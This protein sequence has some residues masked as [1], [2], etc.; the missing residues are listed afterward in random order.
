MTRP[1]HLAAV[2]VAVLL[3][4]AAVGTA[5]A[6]G[7]ADPFE[8]PNGNAAQLL[9]FIQNTASKKYDQEGVA[10]ARQAIIK[11][12]SKIIAGKCTDNELFN[13]VNW[14]A[15]LL[16]PKDAEALEN[17]LK[18]A[19]KGPAA[20]MAHGATLLKQLHEAKDDLKALRG[21][22]EEARK[23]LDTPPLPL[24]CLG[25]A[26]AVGEAVDRIDNNKFACQTYESLQ[27]SL[28]FAPLVKD[29]QEYRK[30]TFVLN[31]LKLVG[32]KM[33]L[34]AK[35]L[36]GDSVKL[37]NLRGKV[38]LVNFWSSA[39]TVAWKRSTT[40]RSNTRS[41]TTRGSRSVGINVDATG[42]VQL[43]ELVKKED[44]PVDDL[45]RRRRSPLHGQPVRRH[46]RGRGQAGADPGGSQ[47]QG[48]VDPRRGGQ[49]GPADREGAG[50][51]DRG[52][53]RR[54]QA[55]GQERQGEGQEEGRGAGRQE[56]G[57]GP[58]PAPKLRDWS[59]TVGTF[60]AKAKFR[61]AFVDKTGTK[62]VKLEL[63]DGSVVSKPLE[64]LSDADQEYVRQR[65]H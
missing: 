37:T 50:R 51:G 15:Q 52:L 18:R 58:G 61:S 59:D 24:G 38:V 30:I 35:T 19:G 13:A 62:M 36:D 21:K 57:G 34:E 7:P 8:V 46:D 32:N 27:H 48:C 17:E 60:H 39:R 56:E 26:A 40:S 2:V 16:D 6:D 41:T 12:A 29:T 5:R 42:H 63:E 22:I 23:F 47:R 10:K 11:A 9:A 1:R 49:S 43:A 55:G 3:A 4:A 54:R 20:Q 14:K 44:N 25:L 31:R 33:P 65:Q 53:G 64:D 45:P 28:G